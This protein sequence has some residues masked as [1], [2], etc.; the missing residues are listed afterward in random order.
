MPQTTD[1][2]IL[3]AELFKNLSRKKIIMQKIATD[4]KIYT[5]ISPKISKNAA[6]KFQKETI[7]F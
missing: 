5:G 3:G 2:L 6:K 7:S 1:T 4:G